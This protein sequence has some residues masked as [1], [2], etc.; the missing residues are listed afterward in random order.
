MRPQIMRRMNIAGTVR[1]NSIGGSIGGK[2]FWLVL[3]KPSSA[4]TLANGWDVPTSIPLSAFVENYNGGLFLK[5]IWL[6]R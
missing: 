5:S 3:Q 2:V 1:Q 6:W 4:K